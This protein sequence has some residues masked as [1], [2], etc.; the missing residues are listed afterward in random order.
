MGDPQWHIESE[1]MAAPPA[2]KYQRKTD[3]VAGLLLTSV[4]LFRYVECAQYL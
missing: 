2:T 1:A 4:L 3:F